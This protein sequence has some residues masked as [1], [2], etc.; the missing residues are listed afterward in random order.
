MANNP[1]RSPQDGWT[2]RQFLAGTSAL[3]ATTCFGPGLALAAEPPPE[4][5]TIRLVHAPAI[6]LAPQYIAEEF[7]RLEGFTEVEYEKDWR[8]YP[9]KAIT[10]NR[11]D[12][13][14]DTSPTLL[15]AVDRGEPIVALS[16]VHAG[17]YELFAHEHIQAIRDLRG[18]SVSIPSR[19]SPDQ[20][21]LMSMLA[22]VGINPATEV[23]WVNG[24]TAPDALTMFIERK[25]DAYMAFAPQG[26]DLR[27]KKVG[28]VIVN[29]AVDRPWSQYFCCM[30][31]G[32]R[33]FIEKYP[34]ATKR[35]LRAFLKAADVCA[36]DP[37][38]AARLL[39]DRGFEPRQEVALEVLNELPYNRWREANPEDTLRFHALRLHEVGMIKSDPNK[40]I[41][42]GTDWRF[43]NELKRELKA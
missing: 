30:F 26:H 7:L 27:A 36:Q 38:R 34:I 19:G 1:S 35:A 18:K 10:E 24:Q 3:T 4:T 12:F 40:L 37:R 8:G 5:K 41:A 16:G 2:R 23:N 28:H 14:Q 15:P 17:C 20:M 22:Y 29:T 31:V 39:V 6:C 43:L 13:T 42:Q 25:V 32:R 21:L 11:A 33:E 9:A